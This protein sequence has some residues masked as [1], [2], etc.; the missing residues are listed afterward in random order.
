M[1]DDGVTDGEARDGGSYGVNPTGVFVPDGIG[2]CHAG[3]FFP[4]AFEN[5][6]ICSG[7]FAGGQFFSFFFFSVRR[8]QANDKPA[9]SRCT[10]FHNDI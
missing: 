5:V 6:N 7:K 10:D 2:K 1:Q 8:T 3:L 9:N 4:L